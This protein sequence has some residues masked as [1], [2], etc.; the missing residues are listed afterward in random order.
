MLLLG[1]QV[2]NAANVY[3]YVYAYVYTALAH[4]AAVLV[5][6]MH[7]HVEHLGMGCTSHGHTAKLAI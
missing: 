5:A 6:H 7:G 4:P 2:S 3:V 1:S